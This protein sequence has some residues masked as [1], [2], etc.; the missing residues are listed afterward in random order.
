MTPKHVPIKLVIR[1]PVCLHCG[2]DEHARE[3]ALLGPLSQLLAEQ[4]A[5][6]ENGG[7][8]TLND[9]KFGSL[10]EEHCDSNREEKMSERQHTHETKRAFAMGGGI[11]SVPTQ[12]VPFMSFGVAASA[13]AH[14]IAMRLSGE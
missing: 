12:S 5:T 10:G 14:T 7:S 1:P 11:P 9:H 8:A 2:Q 6:M 13:S 3:S 4:L